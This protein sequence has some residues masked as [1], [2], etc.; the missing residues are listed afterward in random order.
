MWHSSS[1][2]CF[3]CSLPALVPFDAVAVGAVPVVVVAVAV[4][5]AVVAVVGNHSSPSNDQG[6]AAVHR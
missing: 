4:A 2:A 5:V 6:A 1:L 3:R